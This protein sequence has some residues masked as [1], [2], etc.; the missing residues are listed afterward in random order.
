MGFDETAGP[1]V[2]SVVMIFVLRIVGALLYYL[3]VDHIVDY[4]F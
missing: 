3:H 1:D 4:A 2:C